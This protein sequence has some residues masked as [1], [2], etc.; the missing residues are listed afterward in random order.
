MI[1]GYEKANEMD[2]VRALSLLFNSPLEV[3]PS[4]FLLDLFAIYW[5]H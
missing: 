3:G 4:S 2:M 1:I 5:R